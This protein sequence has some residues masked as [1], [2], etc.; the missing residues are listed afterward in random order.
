VKAAPSRLHSN[1]EPP[2][3]ALKPKLTSGVLG[4]GGEVSI[5]VSG[6]AVSIVHAK[7]AAGPVFPA[8]SV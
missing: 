8:V 5:E 7:L 1:V 4:S 6:A 2:S 3:E